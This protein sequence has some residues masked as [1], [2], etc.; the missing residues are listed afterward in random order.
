MM[1]YNYKNYHNNNGDFFMEFER[2]KQ[3]RERIINPTCIKDNN[4]DYLNLF[5]VPLK[6]KKEFNDGFLLI[7]KNKRN[8]K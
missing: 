1:Y 3:K 2:E 7:T 5:D 6:S 8:N 4:M